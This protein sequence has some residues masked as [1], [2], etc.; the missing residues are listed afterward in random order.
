MMHLDKLLLETFIKSWKEVGEL[1]NID[2]KYYC[3]NHY[4]NHIN[5]YVLNVKHH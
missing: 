5:K 4:D 1:K 2:Q 3:S